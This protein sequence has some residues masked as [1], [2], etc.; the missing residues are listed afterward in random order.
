MTGDSRALQ[1]DEEALRDEHARLRAW[2]DGLQRDGAEARERLKA[3]ERDSG[4]KDKLLQEMLA[5][6]TTARGVPGEALDQIRDDVQVMMN[7]KRSMQEARRVIEEKERKIRDMRDVLRATS[8]PEMDDEVTAAQQHAKAKADECVHAREDGSETQC[9]ARS[10]ELQFEAKEHLNSIDQVES[11]MLSSY[12]RLAKLR[13]EQDKLSKAM[14][15]HAV[16]IKK[17]QEKGAEVTKQ[18]EQCQSIIDGLGD[19]RAHHGQLLQEREREHQGEAVVPL[20]AQQQALRG[21]FRAGLPASG[22]GGPTTGPPLV[23]ECA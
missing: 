1:M 22:R 14:D 19:V 23:A 20:A 9:F 6:A 8:I 2:V 13:G 12:K 15:D 7:I 17:L 18:Q 3:A 16:Q 10:H 4:R 11:Q 5:A 21:A